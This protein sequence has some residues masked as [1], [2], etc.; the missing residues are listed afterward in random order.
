MQLTRLSDRV[1]PPHARRF[2]LAFI[3]VPGARRR[4]GTSTGDMFLLDTGGVAG[5]LGKAGC[6]LG[7]CGPIWVVF[8][9]VSVLLVLFGRRPADADQQLASR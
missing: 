9:L 3:A 2:D 8:P 7:R 1:S 5:R 6:W 4:R